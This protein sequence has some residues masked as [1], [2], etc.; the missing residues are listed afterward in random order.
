MKYLIWA[1]PLNNLYIFDKD[2]P[3]KKSMKLRLTDDSY[4]WSPSCLKANLLTYLIRHASGF[5]VIERWK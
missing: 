3:N 5:H 4:G 1:E 2:A